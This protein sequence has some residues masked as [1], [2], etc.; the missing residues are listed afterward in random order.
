MSALAARRGAD[1]F[2][3]PVKGL[4]CPTRDPNA[5]ALGV[6][7]REWAGGIVGVVLATIRRSSDAPVGK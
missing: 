6:G 5:I 4:F 3:K 2:D 1:A 7:P